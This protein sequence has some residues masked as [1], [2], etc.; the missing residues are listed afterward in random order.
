M[1]QDAPL[2]AFLRESSDLILTYSLDG[3]VAL[4]LLGVGFIGGRWAQRTT[5]RQLDRMP[6]VDATIKPLA[7]RVAK[8]AVLVLVLVAVL[9][10]FG[11]QTS[12]IIALIGAAGLAIG[13]AFKD[14][15][16]NVASGL[17]LLFLRPFNVGEFVEIGDES[18]EVREIGLFLTRLRTADGQYVS[19]PNSEVA[20]DAIINYTRE[21]QR[22]M[23]FEVGVSYDADLDQ[24]EEVL[25]KAAR[26]DD[27]ILAD[28]GP[29][30]FVSALGDS[31][32]NFTVRAWA[33]QADYWPARF[34]L[35]KRIKQRLDDAG[36]GIPFPQREVRV[37]NSKIKLAQVGEREAA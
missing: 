2:M 17:L 16:S 35:L 8:I 11:V 4:I 15:L 21:P 25:L 14:T 23:V 26:E 37:L 10:Q 7:G 20:S 28:P 30:A 24:A 3:L 18:G 29:Q 34:A 22:R 12:S 13:L 33:K 5:E 1:D 32:V 31:S 19:V 36:I 9:G 27:R 6:H